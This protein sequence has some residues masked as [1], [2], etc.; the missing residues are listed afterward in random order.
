MW[1]G[2][3]ER[4][5]IGRSRSFPPLCDRHPPFPGPPPSA[6]PSP[7]FQPC[8]GSFPWGFHRRL[9]CALGIR[10]IRS[11]FLCFRDGHLAPEGSGGGEEM[12]V[13]DVLFLLVYKRGKKSW[14]VICAERSGRKER[15]MTGLLQGLYIFFCRN[16]LQSENK[17]SR[18]PL[19]LGWYAKWSESWILS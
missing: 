7:F 1:K 17:L 11:L 2:E 16:K 19:H 5:C 8:V 4:E 10:R 12:Q 14:K 6:S 15:K 3:I 13:P 18:E 9:I